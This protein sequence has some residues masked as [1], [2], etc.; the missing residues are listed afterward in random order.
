VSPKFGGLHCP[1]LASTTGPGGKQCL[2]TW[3]EDDFGDQLHVCLSPYRGHLA[4]L[5]AGPGSISAKALPV[6]LRTR[7]R[8]WLS[9]HTAHRP[10]A[11]ST[12]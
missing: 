10:G 2:R 7:L 12:S 9:S 8:Q 5:P 3:D 6:W 4:N 11:T 1:S